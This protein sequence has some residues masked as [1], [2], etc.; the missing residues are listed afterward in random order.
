MRIG[1]G[2][3]EGVR[4]QKGERVG[5]CERDRVKEKVYGERE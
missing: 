1:K 3:R 5:V 2:E 4:V